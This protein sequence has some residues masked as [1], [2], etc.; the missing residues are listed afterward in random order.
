MSGATSSGGVSTM[1]QP[2]SRIPWP[3]WSQFSPS[4]APG[5]GGR[6]SPQ[7]TPA[8]LSPADQIGPVWWVWSFLPTP[9]TALSFTVIFTYGLD[10]EFVPWQMVY[11]GAGSASA[12][13]PGQG[14]AAVTTA[15]PAAKRMRRAEC[16]CIPD[17]FDA[18]QGRSHHWLLAAG[19]PKE[20]VTGVTGRG[21]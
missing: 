1:L 9:S 21:S 11:F 4:G 14:E 12:T 16:R 19:S 13:P 10:S 5:V 7:T 2:F 3:C 6:M 17:P 15:A 18:G 20:V 8:A